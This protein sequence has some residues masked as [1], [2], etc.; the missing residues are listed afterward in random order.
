MNPIRIRTKVGNYSVFTLF[1]FDKWV[2]SCTGIDLP[3]DL[4]GY[5]DLAQAAQHHLNIALLAK[6]KSMKDKKH[7][8]E[9][10]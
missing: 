3:N 5:I 9:N 10:L 6:V 8:K 7:V 2:T 4:Y 1:I